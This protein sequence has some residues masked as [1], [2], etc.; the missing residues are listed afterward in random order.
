MTLNDYSIKD[1]KQIIKYLPLVQSIVDKMIINFR[2]G[3]ERDDYITLGVIG[4]MEALDKYNPSLNVSFEHYAKWRIKGAIYDELRKSGSI[5]RNRMDKLNQMYKAKTHLQQEL[6]R[7]PTDQDICE[8]L[9]INIKELHGIY[10][11]AHYLS[12]TFLEETLVIK[13]DEYTLMELI[14]D[15]EAISPQ[16]K[17]EE[18][19]LKMQLSQSIEKLSEKEQIILNLYYKEELPLKEIALVLDVSIS[20]VSQIHGKLL[21]KLRNIMQNSKGV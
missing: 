8:Y 18:E 15:K 16:E 20:R 1:E 3:M 14:E 5:S 11:T 21:L 19:E 9:E 13:D 17:M 12:Y 2:Q 4:L 10:E 6:M 7:E